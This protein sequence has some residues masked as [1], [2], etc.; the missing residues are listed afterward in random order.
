MLTSDVRDLGGDFFHPIA[1]AIEFDQQHPAGIR[2]IP[3]VD[4]CLHGLQRQ[5]IHHL[6]GGGNNSLT[7]HV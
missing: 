2:R 3:R 7:D 5:L 1:Q 4:V 6:D